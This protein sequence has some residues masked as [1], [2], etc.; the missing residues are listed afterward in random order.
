[1][2]IVYIRLSINKYTYSKSTR[3]WVSTLRRILYMRSLV[4]DC[5]IKRV[6]GVYLNVDV[7]A[8]WN[9]RRA[10][11]GHDLWVI[12]VTGSCLCVRVCFSPNLKSNYF[13]TTGLVLRFVDIVSYWCAC[14]QYCRKLCKFIHCNT[15]IG[16][17]SRFL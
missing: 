17:L 12:W 14:D 11:S 10:F 2:L 7:F 16:V 13:L 15:I 1:M 5:L 4:Y 9:G 8:W 3:P 6:S